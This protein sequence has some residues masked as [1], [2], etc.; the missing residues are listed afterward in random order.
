MSTVNSTP[1]GALWSLQEHDSAIDQLRRRL[2]NLP[3]RA[4]AHELN[5]RRHALQAQLTALDAQ[6]G[7]LASAEELVERELA[8]VE[9]RATA[10]DN[11][12]RSPGAGTRDAQAIIHEIDQLRAQAGALE[13]RGLELLE[14]RDGLLSQ[15]DATRSELDAVA[16]DAPAVL[17]AVAAAE[18][19]AG[20]ELATRQAERA[21]TAAAVGEALL[22]TYERMRASMGGVAVAQVV[23]GACTGCHLSLSAVDVEH[24]HRLKP[25]EHMSCE[26]CGRILI[27]T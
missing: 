1:L 4:A 7:E 21:A 3:E 26:Q 23:N 22:A 15:Q 25:G 24:L 2:G 19:G 16:A 17:A 6:L 10:L 8:T 14:Q 13:E 20:A 11:N 27:P 18:G 5:E 9:E 12:L